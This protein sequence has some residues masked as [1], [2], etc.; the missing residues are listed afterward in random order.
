MGFGVYSKANAAY[1]ME[2]YFK[3]CFNSLIDFF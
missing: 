2:M 1:H 3:M